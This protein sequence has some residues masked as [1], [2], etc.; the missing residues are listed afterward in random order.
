[1]ISHRLLVALIMLSQK[2][3]EEIDNPNPS[4][5]AL[6][7]ARAET[8]TAPLGPFR[9]LRSEGFALGATAADG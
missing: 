6:D 8:T 4:A 1:M 2:M 5:K 3:G 7:V 9:L